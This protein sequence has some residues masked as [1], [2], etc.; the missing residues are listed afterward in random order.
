MG[1]VYQGGFRPGSK[2]HAWRSTEHVEAGRWEQ[3]LGFCEDLEQDVCRDLGL[4]PEPPGVRHLP[5]RARGCW[6]EP[7]GEDTSMH[8]GF[9]PGEVGT[10][11]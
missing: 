4:I 2:P 5:R 1:E 8:Q 11:E 3:S 7:T 6:I 10:Q 9:L